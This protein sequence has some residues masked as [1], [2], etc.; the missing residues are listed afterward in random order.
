M[1]IHFSAVHLREMHKCTVDGCSMM[2]SSRRSRNRHSANPNPKLH[3]PHLRRKISPHDGRSAQPH[4]LLLQPP[5]GMMPG[6]MNSL[7]P[8][9]PF[10]LLTPPPDSRHS[11]LSGMDYKHGGELMSHS[12]YGHDD[13]MKTS[14]SE[15]SSIHED[16]DDDEEGIVV[17]GDEDDHDDLDDIKEKSDCFDT[18]TSRIRSNADNQP[19][20]FSI[21][22][23][24]EF[25]KKSSSEADD[26]NSGS[27]TNE[28]SLSVTDSQS[29]KDDLN[30][31]SQITNK[32]KRKSLNPIRFAVP[33]MSTMDSMSEDNDSTDMSYNS[34]PIQEHPEPLVKRPKSVDLC[35]E[36][37]SP[38]L[39]SAVNLSVHDNKNDDK[40]IIKSE[41]VPIKKEKND[42]CDDQPENLTLDLSCKKVAATDMDETPANE[43]NNEILSKS[44]KM[45][46][47]TAEIK[48]EIVDFEPVK[49]YEETDMSIGALRR[50]ENLSQ[51]HI[52]DLIMT[53]GN[54]LGNQFPSLGFMMNATPPSPA[55]SHTSMSPTNNDTNADNDSECDDEDYENGVYIDGMDVP[56]DK[57]NPRKCAACGKV[58]QNH[59]GVKTHYQNVHLKLLHKCNVDGCNAAFPSKRSRDRHSANL[60]L[61]RKLLSTSSDRLDQPSPDKSFTSLPNTLQTEFLARLYADSQRLPFSLEAFKN[62]FP[63]INPFS[64]GL[65]NGSDSRFPAAGHHPPNPFLFPPLGGLPG[66][67]NFSTFAPHLLPHPLNG[68]SAM[69][70][71]RHSSDSHSPISACSPPTSTHV[72]SPISHN[73]DDDRTTPIEDKACVRRTPDGLS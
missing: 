19:T 62:N 16:D 13:H 12:K 17:V 67:P 4:P 46:R 72:S 63:E 10:P 35:N 6:G 29:L 30:N 48:R 57:D 60:N 64:A 14:M 8:F 53:R 68:F 54:I 71:R 11:G 45:F 39:L 28:D 40:P 43:N 3:S 36:L 50:L 27:D 31:S 2:F 7:H 25:S 23:N 38:T 70:H 47:S 41:P 44:E 24:R 59:F 42:I 66:F 33:L 32:R 5:P 22:R 1:K 58:F 56:I 26:L 34:Q 49:K 37:S 52:N 20:D 51:N 65:L 61:H 21:G 69:N 15:G 73:Q 9:N 18:Y 55:R